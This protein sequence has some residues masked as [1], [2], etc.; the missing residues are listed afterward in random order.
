MKLIDKED[1]ILRATNLIHHGLNAFFELTTIFRP[2]YH[3]RKIEC[4]D[5]F[6]AQQFG[7]LASRD[8]LSQPFDDGGLSNPCF[9]EQNRVI[10]GAPAQNLNYALDLVVIRLSNGSGARRSQTVPGRL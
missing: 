5:A 6:I 8:F 3:Q 7:H 4:D 2:G 10:F 1:D 9:T